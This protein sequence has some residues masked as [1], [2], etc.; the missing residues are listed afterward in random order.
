MV[1]KKIV[2]NPWRKSRGKRWKTLQ[3]WGVKSSRYQQA[4]EVCTKKEHVNL[5]HR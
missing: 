4:C 2:K 1:Y 5:L 3:N